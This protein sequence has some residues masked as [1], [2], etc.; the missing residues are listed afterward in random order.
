MPR[1]APRQSASLTRQPA[2]NPDARQRSTAADLLVFL[3]LVAIAVVGRWDQ[4]AW[5]F[6]PMAAASLFAGAY[7]GRRMIALM[8][9][10]SALLLSNLWL[11]SY[12]SLG[13]MLTVY[14]M[15]LAPALAGP[16]LRRGRTKSTPG[17]VAR[18]VVGGAAP[19]LAFF[20][21]TNLAVWLFGSNFSKDI[22]GLLECY[23]L[24]VPFFRS[25]LAGDLLYVGMLFGAANLAGVAFTAAPARSLAASRA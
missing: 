2:S 4:P 19:A 1:P 24:A 13:V 3:L 21:V 18:L 14:A 25:M 17:W 9:P 16:L 15:F 12:D 20:V 22:S 5:N 23:A 10:V 7:F 11:P 6:T 8:V